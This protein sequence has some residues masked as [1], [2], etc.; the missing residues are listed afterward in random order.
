MGAMRL[1]APEADAI[2]DVIHAF[3]EDA[4]VY[5]FGS[6]ADDTA[7]GGDI[8]LLVLS[9]SLDFKDKLEIKR[10]LYEVLGEQRID[11]VIRREMQDPFARHVLKQAVAL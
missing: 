10:R 1:S 2:R 8:D 9:R 7:R 6:R 4:K 3:D 5:L 11:V